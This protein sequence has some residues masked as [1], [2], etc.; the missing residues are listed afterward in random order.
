L[1][2]L[3]LR[4]AP[5][6]K[7]SGWSGELPD[8]RWKVKIAAPP[9]EGRANEELVRFIADSLELPRRSVRLAHGAGGRDKVVEVDLDPDELARRLAA[10]RARKETR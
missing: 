8:G 6:A 4:V 7:S 1:S 5:G 9:I 2:R 10:C 3:K